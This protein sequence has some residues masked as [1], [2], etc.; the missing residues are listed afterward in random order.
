MDEFVALLMAVAAGI[1]AVMLV[2]FA[3]YC[4]VVFGA[5]GTSIPFGPAAQAVA[6]LA[7]GLS[8]Y[9]RAVRSGGA[10]PAN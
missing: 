3:A 10:K 8:V 6:G 2:K 5:D 1:A 9:R 7:A 4:L